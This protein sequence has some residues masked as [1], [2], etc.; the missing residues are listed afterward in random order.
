MKLVK[1][2]IAMAAFAALFVVPSVASAIQLTHPTGTKAPNG[3]LL[4]ATN[5]AHAGTSSILKMSTPLGPVECATATLTGELTNN[6]ANGVIEGTISTAE[7][8]GTPANHAVAHCKSPVGNVTVTPSHSSNPCHTPTGGSAHCSLPWCIRTAANDKI[9]VYGEPLVGGCANTAA[10][11]PITFV[12]HTELCGSATYSRASLTATYTTHP[13]DA[14][15]T[16]D[17]EQPF[18]R[19]TG[20]GFCPSE[21]TLSMAFTLTTD[22]NGVSGEPVYID[23]I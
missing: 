18:K 2:C 11:R 12:L 19:I 14:V 23:A 16:V 17:A 15:A 4:M 21:G 22:N 5:V 10:A 8:R 1:A 7:F 20:S 3:T 6:G 9:T 13:T